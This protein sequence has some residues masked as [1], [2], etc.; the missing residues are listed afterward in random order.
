MEPHELVNTTTRHHAYCREKASD[1]RVCSL[2]DP[3]PGTHKPSHGTEKDRF[4][5]GD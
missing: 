2:Y 1:G 4:S 3:H 5:T